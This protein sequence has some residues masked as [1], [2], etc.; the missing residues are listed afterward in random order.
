[1]FVV[2]Y[3]P[4]DFTKVWLGLQTAV[5][6]TQ[7]FSLLW[8]SNRLWQLNRPKT[9]IEKSIFSLGV[10]IQI[11]NLPMQWLALGNVL[12]VGSRF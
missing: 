6:I 10:G 7:W 5:F 8:F 4:P 12:I 1:M 9:L 2:I 11:A 3:Q